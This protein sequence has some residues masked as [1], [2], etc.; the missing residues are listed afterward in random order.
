MVN[1]IL[2]YVVLGAPVFT[3]LL[4]Y[5]S[6]KMQDVTKGDFLFVLFV[7][8]LPLARELMLLL[9][10]FEYIYSDD[11]VLLNSEASNGEYEDD[12]I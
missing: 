5:L 4:F 9:M 8:C 11:K 12:Q 7:S 6:L 3:G 2:L 10:F 1:A